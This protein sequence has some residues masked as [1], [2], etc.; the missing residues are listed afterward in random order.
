MKTKNR[1]SLFVQQH[2]EITNNP[3][4]AGLLVIL[5]VNP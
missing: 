2:R 5:S 1:L 4:N 3:V